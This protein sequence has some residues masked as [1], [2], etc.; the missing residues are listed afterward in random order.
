MTIL[1]AS[2][3]ASTVLASAI[4][5][6]AT[7]LTV[8]TGAGANF[9]VPVAGTSIFKLTLIDTATESLTEIMHVTAVA[10][11]VF[12]V[13]RGQE[14][15]TA[16]TWSVN[17]I[18]ANMVTAG[19]LGYFA[20]L[21][22]PAFV[23]TPTAPT[24]PA[25]D[26]STRVATTAFIRSLIGNGDGQIPDMSF[27]TSLRA[28]NG[29]RRLPDGMIEQWGTVTFTG[30]TTA[31]VTTLPIAFP[32]AGLRIVSSDNGAGCIP[33]GSI[34]SSRTQA[35]IYAPAYI[36]NSVGVIAQRPAGN[37]TIQWRAIGY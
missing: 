37:I 9:P 8:A 25:T 20:Q 27:F 12:T 2:N 22:S 21:D 6:T 18:A 28:S 23:G 26:N 14:G 10:G 1:L 11:D 19:T 30:T 15:T 24:P 32:T 5:A 35:T 36:L 16:R 34:I 13:Q 3:N 31:I 33:T 29:W 17:D 4:N 7:S